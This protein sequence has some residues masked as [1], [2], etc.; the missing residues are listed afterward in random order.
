MLKLASEDATRGMDGNGLMV[1]DCCAEE[2]VLDD[3][4]VPGSGVSVRGLDPHEEV[5]LGDI[6]RTRPGGPGL[7]P[8]ILQGCQRFARLRSVTV[9]KKNANFFLF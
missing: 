2:C 3:G 4:E 1:P 7:R 6:V 8:D 5:A 9:R